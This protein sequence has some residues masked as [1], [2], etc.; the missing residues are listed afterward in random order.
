MDSI[1]SFKAKLAL[2][3]SILSKMNSAQERVR[4]LKRNVSVLR[5]L[6]RNENNVKCPYGPITPIVR[7]SVQ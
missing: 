4:Q 3:E 7:F 1:Q 5:S 6:L 2:L